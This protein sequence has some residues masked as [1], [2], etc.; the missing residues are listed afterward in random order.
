MSSSECF[1]ATSHCNNLNTFS[2]KQQWLYGVLTSTATKKTAL[3]LSYIRF[4]TNLDF[5][6][7]F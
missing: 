3:R 7:R 1:L 5:L 4:L 6:D 2:S